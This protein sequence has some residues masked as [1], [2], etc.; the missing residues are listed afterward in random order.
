MLSD[1]RSVIQ[2]L[3][4]NTLFKALELI[5]RRKKYFLHTYDVTTVDSIVIFSHFFE[6]ITLESSLGLPI[7][8][9]MT[10]LFRMI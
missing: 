3:A 7:F 1:P 10:F 6:G 4:T 8:I 2:L 9:P 5:K